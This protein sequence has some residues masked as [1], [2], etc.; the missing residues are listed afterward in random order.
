MPGLRSLV[1]RRRCSLPSTHVIST[2]TV[3]SPY[4]S[5]PGSISSQKRNSLDEISKE[6]NENN[7]T[8]WD[9]KT[10]FEI[11]EESLTPPQQE[12]SLHNELFSCPSNKN[13]QING[14]NSLNISEKENSSL[15]MH[16]TKGSYETTTIKQEILQDAFLPSKELETSSENG[17]K[18]LPNTQVLPERIVIK[19]KLLHGSSLSD[20]TNIAADG[21]DGTDNIKRSDIHYDSATSPKSKTRWTIDSIL[22][23]PVDALKLE[24]ITPEKEIKDNVSE[25]I[26]KDLSGLRN[27]QESSEIYS[28]D[29]KEQSFYLT[30]V[31]LNCNGTDTCASDSNIGTKPDQTKPLYNGNNADNYIQKDQNLKTTLSFNN[32]SGFNDNIRR[33]SNSSDTS[34]DSILSETSTV[35]S[36]SSSSGSSVKSCSIVIKRLENSDNYS[37]F[38]SPKTKRKRCSE[39]N[40]P[41]TVYLKTRKSSLP[42]LYI[43]KRFLYSSSSNILPCSVILCDI[44]SN[45]P[46]TK[47]L[48]P[49]CFNFYN[50]PNDVYVNI[51]ANTITL[52]CLTCK[53][54]VVRTLRSKEINIYTHTPNINIIEC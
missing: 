4:T 45:Y 2:E 16:C 10:L 25:T 42:L 22:N 20:V 38:R 51:I 19:M 6:S 3:V 54:L 17:G 36:T 28:Y 26:K 32:I 31:N 33:P 39:T 47:E 44:F 8:K 40:L 41:K 7:C 1:A 15:S 23:Q 12:L 11:K 48:C 29:V 35:S 24:N 27:T 50:F 9:L 18:E 30:E 5:L 37:C 34:E 14:G 13:A 53:W 43:P 46:F 49:R 21:S 52:Q